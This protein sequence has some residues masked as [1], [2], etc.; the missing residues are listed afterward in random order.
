MSDT[1]PQHLTDELLL[2]IDEAA[3]Q[4]EA[5]W[6]GGLRP[7]LERVLE[8][9][10][11]EARGYLVRELLPVELSY[12]HAAGD[13]VAVDEL[14]ARFPEIE[15]DCLNAWL[16]PV[17]SVSADRRD[18]DA[19]ATVLEP[20]FRTATGLTV[21]Q[22]AA[23]V[24]AWLLPLI[25]AGVLPERAALRALQAAGCPDNVEQAVA[26]LQAAGWLTTWQVQQLERVSPGTLLMGEYVLLGPLGKGGM[27]IVYRARHARLDRI[28]A[29][30]MLPKKAAADRELVQRFQ[31]EV[32]ASGQLSHP[33][34]VA[35]HD[36][37][38]H[39]GTQ[40][41]VMEFVDGIDLSRL[42][43][44]S[45]PMKVRQAVDCVVQAAQGL[46]YAHSRGVIHRDIKPQ[47]LMIDRERRVRVLDLGLARFNPQAAINAAGATELTQSGVFMGTVDFMAPEQA[48]NTRKADERSDIYSLGC[49]LWWLLT[50]RPMFEGE[51]CVERILAHHQ[52][53]RPSLIAARRNVP[54][55][56][57]LVFLKMTARRPEDRYASM[58]E[59]IDALTRAVQKVESHAQPLDELPPVPTPLD[60]TFAS[61]EQPQHLI[62]SASNGRNGFHRKPGAAW[63]SFGDLLRRQRRV[64]FGLLAGISFLILV[65]RWGWP[66]PDSADFA[67]RPDRV[68]LN[69]SRESAGI[70]ST[71]PSRG[72]DQNAPVPAATV[73][74]LAPLNLAQPDCDWPEA[75][76]AQAR[77]LAVARQ[78]G[79]KPFNRNS[80]GMTLAVIPGG[81]LSRRPFLISTTEVTVGQFGQFVDE[82][83]YTVR[84]RVRFGL[85]NGAWEISDAYDFRHLGDLPVSAETPA[86]SLCWHDAVAFC[87]WLSR[88]EQ[89]RCRLPTVAEFRQA[90]DSGSSQLFFWGEEPERAVEFAHYLA[91]ARGVIHSVAMLKPNAWGL[92]DALGNERE[93]CG[94]G[95]EW[96]GGSWNVN[97][98]TAEVASRPQA[99]GA[100]GSEV[101]E[102]VSREPAF[103]R[104]GDPHSGQHGAF[105]VLMEL[106][107]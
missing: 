101:R 48:A 44:Q 19:G 66:E 59:V 39:Q 75:A 23:P 62:D 8:Q 34:I 79:L 104:S 89:A 26:C 46:S 55:E 107:E 42:V 45:G 53:E 72:S 60:D 84:S 98:R 51:T 30:K 18:N 61:Q 82:T 14:A 88:R 54:R 56:I 25:E 71:G 93:W 6:Q 69:E 16:N 97:Y 83:G 68:A 95:E 36:A 10:P 17:S 47:N 100:F 15:R 92:F 102:L 74:H 85:R 22:L 49:T 12:R 21:E 90:A 1:S 81:S 50:G 91:N 7:E 5:D 103:V 76:D 52:E 78:F 11:P 20:Q 28:V 80:I 2:L 29:L 57:E 73:S 27:G 35:S 31:R 32:K 43:K 64:L 65:A 3:D 106:P 86:L 9:F 105:R 87:D 24:R 96:Q 13:E 99:G 67:S 38:E 40:Y 4:F 94:T 77:Q 33:N 70:D 37:G 63:Q 58:S 41:L